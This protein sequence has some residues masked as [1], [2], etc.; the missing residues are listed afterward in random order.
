MKPQLARKNPPSPAMSSPDLVIVMPE[1]LRRSRHPQFCSPAWLAF[2]CLPLLLAG[3]CGLATASAAMT[4][5]WNAA[6]S[7]Y[8]AQITDSMNGCVATYN[9]YSNYNCRG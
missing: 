3:L 2:R 8:E 9:A 1:T 6:P 5:H 4:W 7:D